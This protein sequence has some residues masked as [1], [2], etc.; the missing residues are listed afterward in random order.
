MKK[1]YF[2]PITEV[3]Q[4]SACTLLAGSITDTNTSTSL[5]PDATPITDP[6]AMDGRF[7]DFDEY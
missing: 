1:T 6:S 5:D 2:A 4:V 7:F 3:C